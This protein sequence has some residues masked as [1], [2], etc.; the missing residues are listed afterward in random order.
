MQYGETGSEV[1]L[2]S[3]PASITA[4]LL[5]HMPCIRYGRVTIDFVIID[6]RLVRID[7]SF[8]EQ[9]KTDAG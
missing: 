1:K 3:V 5:E 6:G 7:K 4:F 2:T 8:V 9:T